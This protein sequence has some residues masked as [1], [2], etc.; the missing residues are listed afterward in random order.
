MSIRGLRSIAPQLLILAAAAAGPSSVAARPDDAK[1]SPAPGRMFVVGRVLDPAGTPVPRATVMVHA[2]ILGPGPPPYRSYQRQ[3]RIGGARADGSGRF[4]IDAPRTSS[5]HHEGFGAV[6]LAPGYGV[7]WVELDPDDEQPA[8]EITLRPEQVVNGRLFDLQGRPVPGVTLSVASISRDLPPAPAGGRRRTDNIYYG[9]SDPNDFPAWPRPTITDAEGRF[10]VRGVGRNLHA[11]LIG[12]H[13]RF[14]LQRIMVDTDSTPGSKTITAALAPSQILNVRVTYADTGEPV[15]H[16]PLLVS[17]SQGRVAQI[18]EAETDD[19]GRA[20]LNSWPADRAYGVFAYPPSGQPYIMAHGSIEWPKGAVEWSL[21]LALRRGILIH[22]KVT[23]EGSGK[24]VAGAL[25]DFLTPTRPRNLFGS[26]T[27]A[28]T[29]SDGSFGLGVEAGPG[30]I[31][32]GIRGNDYAFQSI[33]YR[34]QYVHSC[35]ALDLKPGIDSQEVNLVVRRGAT[36]T[37]RVVGP[38]GRPVREAWMFSPVI[39]DP[40]QWTWRGWSGQIHGKVRDGRF[41]VHGLTP[42]GEVPVC[43]LDP[44]RKLGGVVKLSARSAAGGPVTVRLE[45]CGAA[46]A[47]VVDPEGKPLAKPLSNLVVNM[48]M[49]PGPV[50]YPSVPNKSGRPAALEDRLSR[51]DP[52]NYTGDLTPNADGRITLLV[53]IPGATYRFI[54]YTAAVRG[55]TGPEIRKEFTVKPGETVDLGDIRI[56]KP[57]R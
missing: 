38:D 36:V 6:A 15:P 32:V 18:D 25:V 8:A 10:I 17:A 27:L 31:V 29:T 33:D 48:V 13:P 50:A 37:G 39:L 42:D 4:R 45:P 40:R 53:L 23:E 30:H 21:D 14:A 54:E 35:K 28:E 12:R 9:S 52:V 41:A 47:R 20:R 34:N 1:P 22:G 3:V 49:T 19:H 5:S 16:A 43:F 46:R 56:E 2:R 11:T 55:Q 51:I 7:G 26:W 24:P 44:T 57:P